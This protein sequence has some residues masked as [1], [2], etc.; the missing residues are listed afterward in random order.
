MFLPVA[1]LMLGC[2]QEANPAIL[3][4][5]DRMNHSMS[6]FRALVNRLVSP[7]NAEYC[8]RAASPDTTELCY[9]GISTWNSCIARNIPEFRQC[10]ST[11]TTRGLNSGNDRDR[12]KSLAGILVVRSVHHRLFRS[13]GLWRDV[14]QWRS[15]WKLLDLLQQLRWI[16]WWRYRS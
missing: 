13:R 10:H 9:H 2:E 15:L 14:Q 3:P 1:A 8:C 5:K 11:G 12:L 4:V 6:S 16:Q 7:L